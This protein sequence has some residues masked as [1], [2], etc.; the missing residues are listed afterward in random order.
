LFNDLPDSIRSS[1]GVPLTNKTNWR[2][3][4]SDAT[5][6]PS[7]GKVAERLQALEDVLKECFVDIGILENVERADGR[8]GWWPSGW[9]QSTTKKPSEH[10]N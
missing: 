9:C 3:F 2:P 6:R 4:N 10:A 7:V 8:R 1:T 5:D